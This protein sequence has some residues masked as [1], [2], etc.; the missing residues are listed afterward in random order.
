MT[1]AG[2]SSGKT[3]IFSENLL[4]NAIRRAPPLR[5]RR[6]EEIRNVPEQCAPHAR[7]SALDQRIEE[8][9][10]FTAQNFVVVD[11][12]GMIDRMRFA[13]DY[14]QMS[15]TLRMPFSM[16]ATDSAS[17]ICA[18]FDRNRRLAARHRRR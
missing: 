6:C 5:N 1:L 11:E 18:R 9:R 4:N 15:L 8:S 14:M 2:N 10:R 13:G 16:R 17:V 7:V 12:H 3:R